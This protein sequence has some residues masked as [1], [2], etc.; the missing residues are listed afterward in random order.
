M[1]T[2]NLEYPIGLGAQVA[3]G[4][5][6]MMINSYE[7]VNALE[8]AKG[9]PKSSIALYIPPN[10]LKTTIGANFE[11]LA[12]GVVPATLGGEKDT[13]LLG[14]V[15]DLTQKLFTKAD[16]AKNF[17]AAG[18]GLAVNNHMALV[19]RGPGE[20]RTHDFVFQF[21]PKDKDESLV[22]QKILTDLKNGMTPR[23]S[24]ALGGNNTRLTAPFFKS[25]RQY[26]IKFM[27]GAIERDYLYEIQTSV[28]TSMTVNHD[29][30]GIVG[31]HKDGA[32]V[33][34]TLSLNFKE[35]EYLLSGDSAASAE[36]TVKTASSVTSTAIQSDYRLKDNITLLQE[37][38][39]GIPNIY[40]FNYKWDSETIWIGVMAQELLDTGYSDAVGMDTE[41]LY[42]V[43]YSR[44]GF[45]MIGLK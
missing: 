27:H 1:A 35:I 39:F 16:V 2:D 12:G 38:G 4:K 30:Q 43:D 22:I 13:D 26:K 28:L 23:L 32:P 8:H 37:E 42:W 3:D 31:F 11:G 10:A 36:A 29:P 15:G 44:L 5:H 20:F 18:A 40:S 21:F 17:M 9:K 25:P 34:T 7:S 41:G 33:Q 14:T 45:P 24:G 19:Y 6:W